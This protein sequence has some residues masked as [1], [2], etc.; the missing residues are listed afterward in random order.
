[1]DLKIIDTINKFI[2]Q[3]NLA[4]YTFDQL[5]MKIN[6]KHLINIFIV[7]KMP[8]QKKDWPF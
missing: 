5:A 2:P 1:M 3:N 6:N 8:F 4:N 7:L